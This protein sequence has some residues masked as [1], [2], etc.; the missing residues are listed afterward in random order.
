VRGHIQL[1]MDY[2]KPS[3]R[4]QIKTAGPKTRFPSE[5][6]IAR[7]WEIHIPNGVLSLGQEI[8]GKTFVFYVVVSAGSTKA[9]RSAFL[10]ALAAHCR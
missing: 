9:E 10:N 4:W 6:E 8:N 1:S 3:G 7:L 5:E 2:H